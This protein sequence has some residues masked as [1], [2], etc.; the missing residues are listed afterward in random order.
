MAAENLK[1]AT[2]VSTVVQ[3]GKMAVELL[4]TVS[5]ATNTPYLRPIA[6]AAVLLLDTVVIVRK[7][8][9]DCLRMAEQVGTIIA[10]LVNICT[11]TGCELP[12][13]ILN[14]IATFSETLQKVLVFV[15]HQVGKGLIKRVVRHLEDASF[16][17]IA[18]SLSTTQSS[19][20]NFS[21]LQCEVT[22]AASLSQIQAV[23]TRRNSDFANLVMAQASCS[24]AS[25]IFRPKYPILTLSDIS[26]LPGSPQ[27]FHGRNKELQHVVSSLL[28][29]D[30]SRIAILGPGGVGKSAGD[31]AAV[32]S[33]H[34]ALE[35]RGHPMKAVLQYLSRRESCC[36]VVLDNLET[37]WENFGGR[38]AVEDFL[39]HLSSIK[40]HIHCC[41]YHWYLDNHAREERPLKVR[42]S[43]PF[44][45]PLSP[46]SH[47]AAKQ[48]FH[49]IT[50]A[51]DSDSQV[52]EL[53]RFTDNLPL[54]VTLM[55]SLVSFEGASP[56]LHR[57]KSERT[58][59]LSELSEGADK[60]SN[61]GTSI[62]M[63]L[64]SPRL[65][66]IP[67]AVT[68]LRLLS[69]LPDGVTDSTLA[70]M[71]LPLKDI[72][73]CRVTLCRTSLAYIDHDRLKV[74]VPIREHLRAF[75]P[76]PV[77]DIPVARFLLPTGQSFL[78]KM[79]TRCWTGLVQRLSA[80]LGNILSLLHMALEVERP[81]SRKTI[82]CIID[83][84]RVTE[85]TDL[86]SRD[87]LQSISG[88]VQKLDDPDLQGR[89]FMA[90]SRVP[91]DTRTESYMQ[92]AI[93]KFESPATSQLE[94]WRFNPK[95]IPTYN[96]LAI[97]YHDLSLYYIYQTGDTNKAQETCMRALALARRT[98][99]HKV[100]AQVLQ[101]MS[102]IQHQLGNLR[103]AWAFTLEAQAHA[104]AAGDLDIE[105]ACIINRVSHFI[106][107]GNYGRASA[108]CL[109]LCRSPKT[110][111]AQARSINMTLVEKLRRDDGT[112][113]SSCALALHNTFLVDIVTGTSLSHES[114]H[115]V[116]QLSHGVHWAV[117][118]DLLVADLF[119]RQGELMRA[120]ELYSKCL[121]I[122]RGQYAESTNECFQRLGDNAVARSRMDS[123]LQ[124]YVLHLA[125]SRNMDDYENS[126]QA[127]RRLGDI[128]VYQ[129]DDETA[130]S[131][132]TLCLEGFTLMDI[133]KAR[134]E[135]LVRLGEMWKRQG[136]GLDAARCWEQALPLFERSSQRDQVQECK[137][138]LAACN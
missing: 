121:T 133:H 124:Y 44:L 24:T 90:L 3:Q 18:N 28:H 80:D 49:D 19:Y 105:F 54:A 97:A 123:A 127:L 108:L 94:V 4:R 119:H 89:Y 102:G 84:A 47:M 45:R 129:G 113:D 68:L 70:E 20:S 63:S 27:I 122:T 125:L 11:N 36:V 101:R 6:G 85:V 48:I 106:T 65:T 95:I 104:Q 116:R 120:D 99:D 72:P 39:S 76:H 7:N 17:Q 10:A 1:L 88:T 71:K 74:L 32:L 25:T 43:R 53:L 57:W 91:K 137:I 42:W 130:R 83:L 55:A 61:L 75:H 131:L 118:C 117:I 93:E 115:A 58:S 107:A 111:Y 14:N 64:S 136:N 35:G 128:F 2:N 15:R 34:F 8:K 40:T 13:S 67:D 23:S 9:E 30:S 66:A 46:L 132:F 134:A 78:R 5:D 135:C 103:P 56:V 81:P 79:G 16:Y 138:R 52:D 109:E 82:S 87:L 62:M 37:T 77:I 126:H 92:S 21:K 73:L 26:L 41:S 69:I 31:I 100:L 33:S 29:E 50:D 112:K 114:I 51:A 59:V 96:S 12:P 98:K 38:S 60:S 86:G 110:E 22:A